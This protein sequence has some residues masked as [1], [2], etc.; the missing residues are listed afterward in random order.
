MN[1]AASP[2][3]DSL[4]AQYAAMPVALRDAASLGPA[5]AAAMGA[6]QQSGLPGPRS[7]AWRYTPLRVLARRQ[8]PAATAAAEERWVP[9]DP[10]PSGPRLVF[11]DGIFVGEL[12]STEGLPAGVQLRSLG[13]VLAGGDTRAV[14]ALGRQFANAAD[15][16]ARANA[17]VAGEGAWLR[18]EEGVQSTQVMHLVFVGRRCEAS[19]L[20]HFR[21]VVEVAAGASIELHEHWIGQD[22]RKDMLTVV[23]QVHLKQG[24]RMRHLRVQRESAES[25]LFARSDVVLARAAHYR[26]LDLECGRGLSRHEL[27]IDLQGEQAR[28]QSSGVLLGDAEA[29]V[30]TRLNVRHQLG[31]THSELVWRGLARGRSKLAFHG[32]IHIEAGAD[33]SDAMLSNRNLLLSETAE[34]NTQPVLVIDADEVKAAHGAT[35]GSLDPVALFYLRSRGLPEAQARALLTEAFCLELLQDWDAAT[36]DQLVSLL[37]PASG[38]T[39]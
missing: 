15:W 20:R 21:L 8:F 38:P 11:V 14:H 19:A 33:G 37:Q 36:R 39:A 23:A 35:V 7:E 24:A 25:L 32:G 26:R 3:L 30:D 13:S 27:N 2:L 17:A 9:A 18:V 12:S 10:L 34:I 28:C 1:A 31:D 29:H 4:A 16:F 22:A 5:R 6:L